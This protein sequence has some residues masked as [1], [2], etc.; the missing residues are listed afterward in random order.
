VEDLHVEASEKMMREM[1]EREWI[2]YNPVNHQ[3]LSERLLEW[4]IKKWFWTDH[5]AELKAKTLYSQNKSHFDA[6]KEREAKS[7]SNLKA[8][9]IAE[10]PYPKIG[11]FY[12]QK[13]L[14]SIVMDFIDFLFDTDEVEEVFV[15]DEELKNYFVTFITSFKQEIVESLTN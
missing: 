12:P 5:D 4:I 7:I 1:Q 6:K 9:I 10:M 11:L 15:S 13:S 2:E 3:V 8:K 14:E